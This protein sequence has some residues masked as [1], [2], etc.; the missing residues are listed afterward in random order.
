MTKSFPSLSKFS[1]VCALTIALV[2]GGANLASANQSREQSVDSVTDW[3][4]Y[5]VNPEL[6]RRKLQSDESD[7]IQEWQAIRAV[8]NTGLRYDARNSNSRACQIPDW[9]FDNDDE[10][11]RDRLADA[12]FYHRHPEMNGQPISRTDR[13]SIRTWNKLKRSMGVAYC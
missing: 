6:N 4:F 12:I 3:L 9:Y 11:F 7:Y 5:N 13:Y 10:A 8:V 2:L 1:A